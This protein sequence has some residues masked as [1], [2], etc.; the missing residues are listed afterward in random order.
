VEFPG[1][2]IDQTVECDLFSTIVILAQ[3]LL[4]E[5]LSPIDVGS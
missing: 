2:C 1:H 5:N 4:S 3:G